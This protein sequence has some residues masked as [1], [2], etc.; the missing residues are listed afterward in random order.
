MSEYGVGGNK[1]IV[2][3]APIVPPFG[4]NVVTASE[5]EVPFFPP[6]TSITKEFELVVET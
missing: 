5:L 4:M 2:P 6:L 3:A 1:A